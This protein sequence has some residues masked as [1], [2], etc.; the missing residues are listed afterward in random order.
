MLFNIIIII[1]VIIMLYH[2][3]LSLINGDDKYK[4]YKKYMKKEVIKKIFE[5]SNRNIDDYE[6]I[7][8]KYKK[9]DGNIDNRLKYFEFNKKFYNEMRK[10]CSTDEEKETFFIN[11]LKEIC[12]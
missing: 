6:I 10:I 11:Y 5:F 2:L 1:Y 3:Y 7:I 9:L 4:L 8:N 12:K